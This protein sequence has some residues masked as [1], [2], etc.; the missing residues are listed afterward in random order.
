MLGSSELLR[1]LDRLEQ[2]VLLV[3]ARAGQ[4]HANQIADGLLRAGDALLVDGGSV[5]CYFPSDT[6]R[7]RRLVSET[8]ASIG[9]DSG[10]LLAVHRRSLGR[11]LS[12]L[13]APLRESGGL[14]Q[15]EAAV[16]LIVSD[17]ERVAPTSAEHLRELYDLTSAEARIA[18]ALLHA[19]RL[20]DIADRFGISL[21]SVRVHLQR[22]FEKTRTH[23][24][25]ELRASL[26]LTHRLPIALG[27]PI[28]RSLPYLIGFDIALD[29][30]D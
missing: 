20:Q 12:V 16:A 5:A 28:V 9:G 18:M 30:L 23:R 26:I 25:A 14:A 10:G 27:W 21:S 19:G 13:V 22:V 6:R 2:G 4:M 3:T 8:A 11:P 17:P 15:D 1:L 29:M 24:Q 7:L